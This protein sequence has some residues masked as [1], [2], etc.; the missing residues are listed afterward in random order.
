MEIVEKEMFL[1]V[2]MKDNYFKDIILLI[3]HPQKEERSEGD[4]DKT[5]LVIFSQVFL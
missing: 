1:V 3:F 5:N 2:E 4:G